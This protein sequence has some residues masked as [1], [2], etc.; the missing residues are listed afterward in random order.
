M[1]SPDMNSFNHYAYGAVYDWVF[2]S[3]GGL[4]ADREVPGFRRA[5][6]KPLMD[7]PL[8]WAETSYDSGYGL[9]SVRWEKS[10]KDIKINVTVPPNTTA[11]MVLPGTGART[12]GGIAFTPAAGG[13]QAELGSGSYSFSY[14][15]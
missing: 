5:F 14:R 12:V 1:W 6:I 10:G 4:D 8:A 11:L 9:F 3:V 2:G 7:G 13:A 15:I